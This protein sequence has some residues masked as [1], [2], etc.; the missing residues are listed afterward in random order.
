M[1]LFEKV[2][3]EAL[4]DDKK[5]YSPKEPWV[6]EITQDDTKSNLFNELGELIIK[7][8]QIRSKLS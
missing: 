8:S 4:K 5:E 6:I 1:N 7:L 3:V 2:I